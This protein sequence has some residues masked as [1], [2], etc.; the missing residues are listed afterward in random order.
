MPY[1]IIVSGRVKHFIS[2]F[3]EHVISK[4]VEEAMR[5]AAD[6]HNLVVHEF[7]VAPQVNPPDD[8]LPHHEWY[9]D[10]DDTQIP[11]SDIEVTLD[12]VLTKQNI[13]YK[14]LI[15]GQVLQP[16]KI[17]KVAPGAFREYME[18]IGKLGGQ[19]KVARLKNDRSLVEALRLF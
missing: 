19:N 5:Q 13:Y 16:L 6:R 10:M 15:E 12:Q 18:S 17:R 8:A 11:L 7:T 2:A 14:D 3:G 9:I 1:C 4:E